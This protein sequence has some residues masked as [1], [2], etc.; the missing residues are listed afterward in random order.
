MNIYL[1]VLLLTSTHIYIIESSNNRLNNTKICVPIRQCPSILA[2]LQQTITDELKANLKKQQC[3]YENNGP[4]VWCDQSSEKNVS[5]VHLLPNPEN[6]ECGTFDSDR[7]IGGVVAQIGEYPWSAI[8]QYNIS[9]QLVPKCGGTLINP[10][11][12]LTSAQCLTETEKDAKLHIVV[13]GDHDS[14]SDLECAFFE[15][16]YNTT[17]RYEVDTTHIHP[18]YKNGSNLH[19]IGL[20]R[21]KETVVYNDFINPICLR[22]KKLDKEINFITVVGWGLDK[23]G[24]G[25]ILKQK[26]TRLKQLDNVNCS[27]ILGYKVEESQICTKSN[28]DPHSCQGDIGG[29]VAATKEDD[30]YYQIGIINTIIDR[31][32]LHGRTTSAYTKVQSYLPWIYENIIK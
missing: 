30:V 27:I 15:E 18:L 4:K 5:T 16:C 23:S 26:Y 7:L 14:S 19:D 2:L 21:L 6:R 25:N 9:N 3:G 12:V 13:L 22:N 8:L 17:Q 28:S 11:Y 20:I 10:K 24:I 32:C 1:C 29:A 31:K